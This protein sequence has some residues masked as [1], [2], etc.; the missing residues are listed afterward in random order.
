MQNEFASQKEAQE[1]LKLVEN[2]SGTSSESLDSLDY[3][4]VSSSSTAVKLS[5][6]IFENELASG[7]FGTVWSAIAPR[8]ANKKRFAIK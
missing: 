5:D 1:N 2:S 3:F 7:S 8:R 6:F 4:E